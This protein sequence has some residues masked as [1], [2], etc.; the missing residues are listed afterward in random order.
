M[1]IEMGRSAVLK[2]GD[3]RIVCTALSGPHFAP[4]LFQKAGLDPFA[5]SVLIAKSP[6][7]FRAAYAPRAAKILLV[8]APG[9]APSDYWTYPYE[10]IARPL[11]PWDEFEWT[12]QAEWIP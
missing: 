6:C 8:R 9:C 7:G 5:Q 1:A 11:W 12:P 2:T 4:E 10:R 3:V